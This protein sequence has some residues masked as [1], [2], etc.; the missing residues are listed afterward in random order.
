MATCGM[1]DYAGE[2]V[3]RVGMPAKSGVAGGI[4]AVMPG[5]LAIGV[6]SPPLDSAGNSVRGVAVCEALSEDLELHF[7]RAPRSRSRGALAASPREASRPNASAATWS[8]RCWPRT[9]TKSS[10]TSSRAI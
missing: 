9:A 1:Y 2:W 7:L 6:F 10:P 8:A 3:Y 4:L 5:Q